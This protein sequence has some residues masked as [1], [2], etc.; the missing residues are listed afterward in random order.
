M[1]IQT[2]PKQLD[3]RKAE[4]AGAGFPASAESPIR[5]Q[6][7]PEERLRSLGEKLARGEVA[8]IDGLGTFD[9]QARIR[10]SARTILEVYR[11][12]NAAQAK[13]ETVTPAAQWLLDNNYLVEETIYQIK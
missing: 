6:F 3:P 1:N 10:D 12:V 8:E 13:G 2:D 4:L 5:S 9:F 11:T 7:L